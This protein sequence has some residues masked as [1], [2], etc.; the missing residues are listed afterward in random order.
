MSA[1]N[2]KAIPDELKTLKRWVIWKY[3]QRPGAKKP[4]K[5]PYNAATDE[6][7]ESNNP[8]TWS[9]FEV[10]LKALETGKYEGL[11]FMFGHEGSNDKTY[12]GIDLDNLNTPEKW[13]WANDIIK[14]FDSY[15]EISPS[16]AGVH[17]LIT[18]RKGE[19]RLRERTKDVEIYDKTHYFTITGDRVEGAPAT[20]NEREEQLRSF[21]DKT[22][23]KG[24]EITTPSLPVASSPILL[25]EKIETSPPM[26]TDLII[27]NLRRAA[28]GAKFKKLFEDGDISDYNSK[29]E[30]DAGLAGIIYFRTQRAEQIKEI[31]LLSA[32]KRLDEGGKKKWDR[33]D[34]LDGTIAGML[35]KAKKE[36]WKIWTPDPRPVV[37]YKKTD[38]Y[39]KKTS[40]ILEAIKGLYE[41]D[42]ATPP[43]LI[44][45][46]VLNRIKR[47]KTKRGNEIVELPA[48]QKLNEGALRGLLNRVLR[49]MVEVTVGRGEKKE[50]MSF[51]T[52]VESD[53]ITD[54]LNLGMP[55]GVPILTGVIEHP[56]F[57]PDGSV[58]DKPGYDSLTGTFYAPPPGFQL[59]ERPLKPTREDAKEAAQYLFD[60]VLEGFRWGHEDGSDEVNA[61]AFFLRP[62]IRPMITGLMPLCIV[63]KIQPQTGGSKFSRLASLILT[64]HLPVQWSP[65]SDEDEF[66][67]KITSTLPGTPEEILIDNA[68][69]GLP[70]LAFCSL[71][72]TSV[73]SDRLLGGNDVAS[74]DHRV[75][76]TIN[77]NKLTAK[78]EL[79]LRSF[80]ISLDARTAHPELRKDFKR[81]GT[82]LEVWIKENRHIILA[83]LITIVEAWINAGRPPATKTW[84]NSSEF[85]EAMSMLAALCDFALP[86]DMPGFNSK[87]KEH[88]ELEEG[89][90]AAYEQFILSWGLIFGDE[91]IVITKLYAPGI[92][93]RFD[94]MEIPDE[95]TASNQYGDRN[96][97][98][99]VKLGTALKKISK[100]RFGE[101]DLYLM[102]KFNVDRKT[103]EYWMPEGAKY[104]VPTPSE[105]T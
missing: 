79:L 10:A 100:K 20:V 87:A 91:K 54:I 69:K 85:S 32:L 61:L 80:I 83:K 70:V 36:K 73:W 50:T 94:L 64:G 25:S 26:A 45:D 96:F 23:K 30:A 66:R 51:E 35:E 2:L 18:G 48:P 60:E 19:G 62:V 12:T 29:S 75:C 4:T 24:V 22:F 46:G 15:T 53:V 105:K 13:V 28:N 33:P 74:Y 58:V 39:T 8:A 71:L 76:W 9:T 93:D 72:T 77:G 38:I 67:K 5:P 14:R 42:T 11:G 49:V 86:E 82:E 78:R 59:A 17:I 55:P 90:G 88:G 31:M 1:P 98:G 103:Y 89:D 52:G 44:K 68:D 102:A 7:A 37:T 43:L 40:L 57:R 95:L 6:L 63:D 34:Y 101:D 27:E 47:I 104:Y 81:P 99:K 41:K 65:I 16:G 21:Y 56:F 3:V 92:F 84:G 97:I